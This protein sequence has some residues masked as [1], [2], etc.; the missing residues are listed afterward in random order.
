[1]QPTSVVIRCNKQSNSN[2]TINF[3]VSDLMLG[4]KQ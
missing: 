4:S 1:M 2:M 3:T